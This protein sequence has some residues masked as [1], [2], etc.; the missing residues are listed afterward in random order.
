MRPGGLVAAYVWDYAGGMEFLR[1]FWDAA[2]AVD[3]SARALDEGVRFPLC[4]PEPL[5]EL[6]TEAGLVETTA[7]P[8]E[9]PTRFAGFADLWDPFLAGQGPAPGY[10]A[11]LSPDVRALLRETLREAV[12]TGPDGTI[13]LKARAWAVRGHRPAAGTEA[14]GPDLHR[15]S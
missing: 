9:V 11:A 4:R 2:I 15:L 14:A 1:H 7:T 8:I 5:R 13:E 10:A 6:W 12:P 3:P